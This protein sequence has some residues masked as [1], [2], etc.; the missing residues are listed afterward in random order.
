MADELWSLDG[1]VAMRLAQLTLDSDLQGPSADLA[2]GVLA[3]TIAGVVGE[4]LAASQAAQPVA[5]TEKARNDFKTAFDQYSEKRIRAILNDRDPKA[6]VLGEEFGVFAAKDPSGTVRIRWT[7]D[8]ID[9]TSEFKNGGVEWAVSI[10]VEVDGEVV[11]GA[12]YQ[13]LAREMYG[14]NGTERWPGAMYVAVKGQGAY[15][16]GRRFRLPDEPDASLST[17]TVQTGVTP[18]PDVQ[19]LQYERMVRFLTESKASNFK[20]SGSAALG[21]I[22]AARG[23]VLFFEGP[24]NLW[25][26]AAAELFAREAGA[27]TAIREVPYVRNG[28]QTYEV[29]VGKPSLVKE[30]NAVLD[31]VP[32][33]FAD[34]KSFAPDQMHFPETRNAERTAGRDRVDMTASVH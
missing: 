9:G 10:A 22:D 15:I 8:P 26:Y 31:K 17:A 19:P 16:N 20:R 18:D 33:V 12:V 23:R 24:L 6:E 3:M 34:Q 25:D 21:M 1:G 5:S 11:A 27:A 29:L 2:R 28:H 30:F 13:P 14:S 7:I 4:E 32:P